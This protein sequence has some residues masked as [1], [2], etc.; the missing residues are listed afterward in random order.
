MLIISASS[1]LHFWNS[2]LAFGVLHDTDINSIR[3][4]L[5]FFSLC[6]LPQMLSRQEVRPKFREFPKVSVTQFKVTA[7]RSHLHVR[8]SDWPRVTL[9]SS[10]QTS[11]QHS[12]RLKHA[13]STMATTSFLAVCLS[14]DSPAYLCLFL[15]LRGFVGSWWRRLHGK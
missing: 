9:T 7:A 13:V 3:D 14:V 4:R 8:K 5:G 6:L 15:H 1:Q 10:V 12:S 11:C 2:A